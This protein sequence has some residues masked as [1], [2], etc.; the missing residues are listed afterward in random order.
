MEFDNPR[1][2]KCIFCDVITPAGLPQRCPCPKLNLKPGESMNCTK[3]GSEFNCVEGLYNTIPKSLKCEPC[4]KYLTRCFK[5]KPIIN[6]D[7]PEPPKNNLAKRYA[8]DLENKKPNQILG[9]DIVRYTMMLLETGSANCGAEFVIPIFNAYFLSMNDSVPEW[10]L[11]YMIDCSTKP[12]TLK[13][14][15]QRFL[16]YYDP[17][18]TIYE[19]LITPKKCTHLQDWQPSKQNI[20]GKKTNTREGYL[21]STLP[22]YINLIFKCD[23]KNRKFLTHQNGFYVPDTEG[24][25]FI[26]KTKIENRL[27]DT[28]FNMFFPM[29]EKVKK[30]KAKSIQI[31]KEP[32]PQQKEEILQP[33]LEIVV[34]QIPLIVEKNQQQLELVD[35]ILPLP[36]VREVLKD[37]ILPIPDPKKLFQDIQDI[38]I[39]MKKQQDIL[40]PI[41][42]ILEQK[43]FLLPLPLNLGQMFTEYL[44]KKNNIILP[45]PN[46]EKM[47]NQ[48]KLLPIPKVEEILQL[49]TEPNGIWT[50]RYKDIQQQQQ[51]RYSKTVILDQGIYLGNVKEFLPLDMIKPDALK[52]KIFQLPMNLKDEKLQQVGRAPRWITKQWGMEKYQKAYKKVEQLQKRKR[53]ADETSSDEE[54][55]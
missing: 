53:W 25:V 9:Y 54:E 50:K 28:F 52:D 15:T 8:F 30:D 27:T 47:I 48:E 45:L 29:E 13:E 22:E 17:K 11:P 26:G 42:N 18:S 36:D 34:K 55:S 23:I 7:K 32:P 21:V 19:A 33:E 16:Q 39:D 12:A 51:Q 37:K 1:G 5:G 14:G 41:P 2:R 4:N 6:L 44:A 43:E 10:L 20:G 46:P 38:F 24:D 49:K 31:Q 35:K 40:L 3:C